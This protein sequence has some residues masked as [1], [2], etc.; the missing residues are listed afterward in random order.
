MAKLAS[1]LKK[2]LWPLW[3]TRDTILSESKPIFEEFHP[4]ILCTASGR[5]V[6]N[7]VSR[8]GSPFE[9]IQG[10]GDDSEGWSQ[11]C[12]VSTLRFPKVPKGESIRR[13]FSHTQGLTPTLFWTHKQLLLNTPEEKLPSL[14]SSLLQK[15]IPPPISSSTPS[16]ACIKPTSISIGSIST[17]SHF[18]SPLPEALIICSPTAISLP[19]AT[20]QHK[21]LHLPIPPNKNSR[22]S[23]RHQL[24][25]TE[26][27]FLSSSASASPTNIGIVCPTGTDLAVGI[28]LALLCLYY[29][30]KGSRVVQQGTTNRDHGLIDK[31]FIAK[32]LAWIV[33]SIP[34]ANP[35][36]DTLRAINDYLMSGERNPGG[37][38]EVRLEDR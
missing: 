29:D 24:A 21:I 13:F 15:T 36:R 4:I 32:R 19:I 20:Q 27:F 25:Q 22:R 18:H 37:V 33:M 12:T 35:R 8:H 1:K 28:A 26:P 9:Y 23:L 11:V 14:I 30:D 16:L 31:A 5:V 10:A 7:E 6:G 38:G 17:L 34:Q 2:P 3:I